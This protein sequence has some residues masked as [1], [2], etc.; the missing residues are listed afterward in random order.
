VRGLM[1]ALGNAGPDSARHAEWAERAMAAHRNA[2]ENLVIFA[3]LVLVA[4]IAGV[5]STLTAGA[6]AVYFF[7]RLAHFV[8]QTAGIPVLR[9]LVFTAG[10]ICQMIFALS[11]LGLL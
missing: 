6:A 1:G 10:W 7:A 9:T 11:I 8:I 3:P 4:N 5:S 2:V